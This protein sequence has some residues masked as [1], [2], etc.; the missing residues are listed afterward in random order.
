[1][2]KITINEQLIDFDPPCI[3]YREVVDL[4]GYVGSNECLVRYTS[5]R[6]GAVRREA[7]LMPGTA[8]VIQ[9]VMSFRVSHAGNA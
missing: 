6:D 5:K 9:D 1:M 2:T 4:A 7:T 8:V 3:T